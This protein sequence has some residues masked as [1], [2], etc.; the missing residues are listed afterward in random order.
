MG[1]LYFPQL[2]S[3]AVAQYPIRKLRLG[4]TI[5]N[6]LPDGS[7]ILYSD[8]GAGRLMWELSY[9][10]LSTADAEAIQAHFNACL[11]PF[12]AF[13][14]IDPTENML[15]SSSDLRAAAWQNS[16]LIEV[17]PGAGGPD[18]GFAAFIATNTSQG[19]QEIRQSLPLPGSYQY[20]FSLYAR[21]AQKSTITLI[22]R[23]SSTEQ[24]TTL[25][26]GP[27]WSR[28][29]SSGRLNDPEAN[30]TVAISLAAGQQLQLYGVQLE[31]QLAPSRYR[32]T[33]QAGGLFP[34]AHWA[35][36]Q[37]TMIAD[38][39]NLFSTSFSIETAI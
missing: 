8:P 5:K 11:G 15:L 4:R 19:N 23:A 28:V 39:P 30:F 29:V 18:G 17:T 1:N 36:D 33:T 25:A 26:V 9:T 2:A 13:T 38:A 21:S 12:H 32:P 22:R 16:S 24:S 14:F 37:L 6:V 35:V 10:G 27:G 3:G 20:C 34:N 31:A 7:M